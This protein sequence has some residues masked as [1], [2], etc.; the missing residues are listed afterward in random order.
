MMQQNLAAEKR[1][2]CHRNSVQSNFYE[3]TDTDGLTILLGIGLTTH[4]KIVVVEESLASS[5]S[6]TYKTNQSAPI[7]RRQNRLRLAQ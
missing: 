7:Y 1:Q 6:N 3:W 2:I 5:Q 4:F